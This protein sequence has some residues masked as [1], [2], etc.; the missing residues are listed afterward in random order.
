[1]PMRA[2]AEDDVDAVLRLEQMGDALAALTTGG[3]H[4]PA[5]R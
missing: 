5:S 2:I 1:M 3:A 4:D